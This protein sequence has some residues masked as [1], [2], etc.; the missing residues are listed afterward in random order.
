MAVFRFFYVALFLCAGVSMCRC[1]DFLCVGVSTLCGQGTKRAIDD[2]Y[3][4]KASKFSDKEDPTAAGTAGNNS[5]GKKDP[6]D[7]GNKDQSNKSNTAR[8]V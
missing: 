8:S 2:A 6:D 3:F 7:Q 5:A 1:F 4:K